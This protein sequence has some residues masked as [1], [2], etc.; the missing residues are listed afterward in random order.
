MNTGILVAILTSTLA[1]TI[2]LPRAALSWRVR[3]RTVVR[4][5]ALRPGLLATPAAFSRARGVATVAAH[6]L[7]TAACNTVVPGSSIR[8]FLV[9]LSSKCL[10]QQWHSDHQSSVLLDGRPS[11]VHALG[12]SQGPLWP[13]AR[14]IASQYAQPIS[15]FFAFG[16]PPIHQCSLSSAEHPPT[17]LFSFHPFRQCFYSI[18]LII[19]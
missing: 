2:R 11:F 19:I 4:A 14:R 17:Q 6:L 16:R 10:L 8:P 1:K 13:I 15:I 3:R 12:T 9:Q 7:T 5:Y 18:V